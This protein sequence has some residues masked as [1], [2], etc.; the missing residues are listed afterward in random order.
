M[1]FITSGLLLLPD[2]PLSG[3]WRFTVVKSSWLLFRSRRNAAAAAARLNSWL[4]VAPE[5]AKLTQR[6]MSKIQIKCNSK[7]VSKIMGKT[8]Y[9]MNACCLIGVA[10]ERC[11]GRVNLQPFYQRSLDDGWLVC[12]HQNWQDSECV[13]TKMIIMIKF[14]IILT[15]KLGSD[16]FRSTHVMCFFSLLLC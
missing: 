8:Y 14:N 4:T 1:L 7:I 6:K 12:V 3:R 11:L 10:M 15:L 9:L 2:K 5:W 16:P 13:L